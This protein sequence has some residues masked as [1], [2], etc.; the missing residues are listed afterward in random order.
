MVARMK[1]HRAA[2]WLLLGT[3]LGVQLASADL[4]RA[5]DDP[6]A[7]DGTTGWGTET[8]PFE[9]RGEVTNPYTPPLRP[10]GRMF[11]SFDLGVPVVLDVDRAL[12]RPGANLHAQGG[13]DLGYVALFLHGG[14]RWIPVDFDRASDD[15]PEYA[16]EGRDPLK[17]PYFGFGV[18]VQ[19]PNRSRLIPYLS[20]SVDFNWWNFRESDVAC[21]GGYYYW[22]CND[23]NVYTFTPGFSGRLG[24][25]VHVRHG[26]YADF[27]LGVSMS[28]E[29]DFFD[30]NE[31]WFEPFLGIAYRR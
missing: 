31:V 12:I 11:G 26:V 19:V 20:A 27:G 10:P 9:P 14:W 6:A 18:R 17:N 21:A 3:L 13:L 16:G 1:M 29:G 30:R 2:A 28:L 15:H 4:A 22:Y 25:L 5:W 24:S 23:Y 7:W 8:S